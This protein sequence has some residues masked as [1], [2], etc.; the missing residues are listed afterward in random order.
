METNKSYDLENRLVKFECLCLDVCDKLPSTKS[1]QN[2]DYQLSKSSSA[3][4][5][6]YGEA[7]AAD[8]HADFIHKMK[9]VLKE[10]RETRMCL[11]VI[12]EKPILANENSIIALKECN[13]LMAIFIK[14]IET[15]KKNHL[16]N[17]I[18]GAEK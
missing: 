12:N 16:V 6:I 11:R 3:P 1:G 9:L 14:S 18:I 13:E 5:L 15:S 2:L 8:S 17:N 4:A 10:I 7:Q